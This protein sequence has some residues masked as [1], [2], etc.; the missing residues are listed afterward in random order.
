MR[1]T[2]NFGLNLLDYSD[3]LSPKPL[4]ENAAKLDAALV[5]HTAAISGRVMMACG[6]YE[7]SGTKNVTILTPG[8]K[9]QVVLVRQKR[10]LGVGTGGT[11]HTDSFT[12]D[13]GWACW[14]GE[15]S[16][17]T[18]VYELGMP[19]RTAKISFTAKTGSLSWTAENGALS[20]IGRSINNAEGVTYEWIAF[21]Y[22]EIG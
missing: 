8:F 4:N 18:G 7:G 13:G 19:S 3:Q 9:P 14:M 11:V 6:G 2:E 10:A 5:E 20:G 1:K 17:D 21:G 12:V 16:L 22:G 15:E